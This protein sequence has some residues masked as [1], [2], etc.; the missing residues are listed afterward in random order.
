M[1]LDLEKLFTLDNILKVLLAIAVGIML[2]NVFFKKTET[3]YNYHLDKSGY[4]YPSD[5]ETEVAVGD[6]IDEDMIEEPEEL[7]DAMES[8]DEDV[9][10]DVV[11]DDAEDDGLYEYDDGG[12]GAYDDTEDSPMVGEIPDEMYIESDNEDEI[13]VEDDVVED[14]AEDETVVVDPINA[15]DFLYAADVED[16]L[17]ENFVLYSNDVGVDATYQ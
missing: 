3:Y 10:E 16:D 17:Q 14:D 1:K 6:A 11:V 15:Y 2:Y 4:A 12:S 13:Y 7:L 8:A 9:V 5:Y